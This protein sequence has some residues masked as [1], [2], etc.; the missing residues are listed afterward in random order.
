LKT[1]DSRGTLAAWRRDLALL[2]RMAGM[3]WF[4]STEGARL[5]REYRDC[6]ARGETYWVDAA[7]P[8][9]HREKGRGA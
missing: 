6:E 8:T 7:G 9:R 2:R 5:R 1:L 3:L 4:Y